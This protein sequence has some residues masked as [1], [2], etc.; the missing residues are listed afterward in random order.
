MK[1]KKE[2]KKERKKVETEK[3]RQRQ[4]VGHVQGTGSPTSIK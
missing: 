4:R 2:R 3:K 1:R